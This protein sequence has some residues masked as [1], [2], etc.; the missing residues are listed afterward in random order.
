M[1]SSQQDEVNEQEEYASI[2]LEGLLLSQNVTEGINLWPRF[3]HEPGASA[4][5]IDRPPVIGGKLENVMLKGLTTVV[6]VIPVVPGQNGIGKGFNNFIERHGQE[7]EPG[8][9]ILILAAVQVEQIDMWRTD[10]TIRIRMKQAVGGLWEEPGHENGPRLG[11]GHLTR[12]VVLRQ[13][14]VEID[15]AK[16]FLELTWDMI[17]LFVP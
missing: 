5:G 1:E 2:R 7:C 11:V 4:L 13:S 12:N 8:L 16:I 14:S 10:T 15:F 6:T 17:E 3:H 9:C